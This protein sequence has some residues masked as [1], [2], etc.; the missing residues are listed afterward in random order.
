MPE[1]FAAQINSSACYSLVS[2]G[3]CATVVNQICRDEF[4]DRF[5][6]TDSNATVKL[7]SGHLRATISKLV[8]SI[9]S[10]LAILV[11]A[12]AFVFA[13][14]AGNSPKLFAPGVISGPADELSPAFTP[15]GKTVFFTRGNGSSSTILYSTFNHGKWSTP[16]VAPFSG[17]WN[18]L[19]AAMSPDGNFLVF[20]SNRP[21]NGT[22][23]P[24]DGTF[25]G[26]L[27]PGKGG[28]LW[29]VDR[30]AKGW[31][32]PR[33][34]ADSI[35]ANG[36]VFSPAITTDGSLYF[37]KPDQQSGIFRLFR[38]QFQSGQYQAP[39]AVQLGE[40]AEEEVD[41]AIAPDESFIVYSANVKTSGQP[42]RLKIAFRQGNSWGKPIDLGDE[43]NEQGSNIEARLGA[44]H[45]SLYFS[46]NT[47]P[48]TQFPK[49]PEQTARAL[50][51]M[52]VWADGRQNIWYVS[53]APWLDQQ[54]HK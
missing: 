21:A 19:E 44:D 40:A 47:V 49:T 34:L 13:Q 1:T 6:R 10:S 3:L 43:V 20:A 17:V 4:R 42:K 31:S 8:R 37:M 33:R 30:T 48:P 38:S 26:K 9:V 32:E 35:N 7:T 54:S 22:G 45:R 5:R 27:F 25:N 16:V 12:V 46:T 15:D 2:L 50:S 51:E 52:E 14:T 28:N 11:A 23:S 36:A 18:D 24:I 29:R 53:L 41:P 39:A